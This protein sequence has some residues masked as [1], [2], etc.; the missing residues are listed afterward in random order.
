MRMK[1]IELAF[2]D[3]RIAQSELDRHVVKPTGP[4]AAIEM[5]QAWNDDADH[6][7]LDVGPRL[8]EHEEIEAGAL[9][10]VYAGQSLLARVEAAEFHIEVRPD[11]RLAVRDQVRVLLQAERPRAVIA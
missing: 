5:A 9:D 11:R 10:D 1:R 2:R 8:I 3:R 7:G 4:E 6:R